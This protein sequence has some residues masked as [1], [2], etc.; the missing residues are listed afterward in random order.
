MEYVLTLNL[1]GADN[2]ESSLSKLT[3]L[4]QRL[5]S[6][7]TT[8]GLAGIVGT[9]S[10]V[11]KQ[12][13]D[14]SR[15]VRQV[16][17]GKVGV[18]ALGRELKNLGQ[19]P[20]NISYKSVEWLKTLAPKALARTLSDNP[21]LQK[22]WAAYQSALV[23]SANGGNLPWKQ[24]NMANRIGAGMMNFGVPNVPAMNFTAASIIKGLR[25]T[26]GKDLAKVL[27]MGSFDEAISASNVSQQGVPPKLQ[28]GRSMSLSS[29]PMLGRFLTVAGLVAAALEGF[30]KAVETVA[31]SINRGFGIYSG[32]GQSG[33]SRQFFTQRQTLA[34]IFGIEGNPNQVFVFGKAIQEINARISGAVSTLA[35][36]SPTL[37]GLHINFDILKLDFEALAADI[38][39]SLAPA[40]NLF[41]ML[42]DKLIKA[43]DRFFNSKIAQYITA[44][45]ILDSGIPAKFVMANL[46]S[47]SSGAPNLN[48]FM[49]QLPASTWE[50]MGLV[51][52]GGTPQST[53]VQ[54]TRQIAKNTGDAVRLLKSKTPAAGQQT[55]PNPKMGRPSGFPGS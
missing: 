3:S 43:F 48:P 44:L 21:N 19:L 36:T 55:Y 51:I 40:L 2:V 13:E 4:T 5:S 9:P 45:A 47:A 7:S 29:I 16:E 1:Q 38:T 32:A 27:A 49:K 8:N 11:S 46:I 12:T 41:A 31:G 18:H 15:L 42:L 26:G 24:Y 33:L 23:A 28:S 50:R 53:M 52:G 22:D 10:A 20:S 35:K 54:L 6:T 37:A 34:S 14:I 17:Q 39:S 30:R 25:E